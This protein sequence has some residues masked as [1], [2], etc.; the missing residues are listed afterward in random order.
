MKR[1]RAAGVMVTEMRVFGDEEGKGSKGGVQQ[2]GQ[3]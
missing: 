2:R 1:A 3:W